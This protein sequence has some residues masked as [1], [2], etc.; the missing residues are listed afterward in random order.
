LRVRGR[1]FSAGS[2]SAGRG[3]G[4][5]K[6]I[7]RRQGGSLSIT[8][9]DSKKGSVWVIY[10]SEKKAVFRTTPGVTTFAMNTTRVCR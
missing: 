5:V 9:W 2:V 7:T 8:T 6:D 10:I 3:D 1:R 4:R